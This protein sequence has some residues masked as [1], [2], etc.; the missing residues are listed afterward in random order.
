[1]K[2]LFRTLLLACLLPAAALAEN[3]PIQR[4]GHQ[5]AAG[6]AA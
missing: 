3:I 4:R 6:G 5:S 1:M 2:P